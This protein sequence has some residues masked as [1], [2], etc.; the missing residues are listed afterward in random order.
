[1]RLQTTIQDSDWQKFQEIAE[2]NDVD[3]N[4][5]V[6]KALKLYVWLNRKKSE[7]YKVGAVSQN[8][9]VVTTLDLD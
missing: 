4:E 2:K 9:E 5:L 6:R 7:G 1:M 8:G 3:V